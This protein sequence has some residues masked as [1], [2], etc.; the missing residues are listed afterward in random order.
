MSD[1][2]SFT[3]IIVAGMAF[4]FCMS[5]FGEGN[6]FESYETTKHREEEKTKREVEKTKQLQYQFKLD[7]LKALKK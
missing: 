1:N 7:S 5:Y 3:T 4:V 6:F 2:K